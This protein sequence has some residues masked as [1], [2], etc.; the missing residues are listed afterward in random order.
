[1]AGLSVVLE[2]T[3][4]AKQ[5]LQYPARTPPQIINKATLLNATTS[6]SSGAS[7]PPASPMALPPPT[8]SFLHQCLLCRRELAD[9]VDIYI[10]RGDR[11]FCSEE[12]RCRHIL[13]DDDDGA[14]DCAR[15][16]AAD[17]SR[18]RRQAVAGGFAF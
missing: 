12:C 15:V 17:R 14:I 10:Y 4:T 6:K 13:L 5:Q 3:T 18:R 1:M 9:G 8:C 7:S 16:A 2:T 11:A